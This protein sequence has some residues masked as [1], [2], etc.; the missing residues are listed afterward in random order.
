MN[1][2]IGTFGLILK[3][4]RFDKDKVVSELTKRGFKKK[5]Y[6]LGLMK[7][8]RMDGTEIPNKVHPSEVSDRYQLSGKLF[9][10]AFTG[11]DILF[12]HKF[13]QNTL[14]I[15]YDLAEYVHELRSILNTS[16]NFLTFELKDYELILLLR[17]IGSK[18]P[19]DYFTKWANK[20][21]LTNEIASGKSI[22]DKIYYPEEIN[23]RCT[24]KTIR[25]V[26]NEYAIELRFKS[27]DW[28]KLLDDLKNSEKIGREII[29]GLENEN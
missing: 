3:N 10:V 29:L 13:G 17:A 8:Y 2:K 1:V 15:A 6:K 18:K 14:E 9:S 22:P 11:D 4:Q 20:L 24:T 23:N 28:M 21:A 27:H 12:H 7:A 25:I 26:E 16:L 19:Q 5:Y